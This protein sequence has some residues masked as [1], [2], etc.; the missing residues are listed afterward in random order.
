MTGLVNEIS[1]TLAEFALV[2]DDYH[3]IQPP[4]IHAAVAFML[5]NLV[6]VHF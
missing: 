3:L 4:A 5:N 2:L 6:T 1:Q